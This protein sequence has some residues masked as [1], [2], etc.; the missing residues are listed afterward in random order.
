MKEGI[1]EKVEIFFSKFRKQQY[2]KGELL[3]RAQDAPSG[4]FYLKKGLV[5]QY[6]ISQKGEEL[7]VNVFKNPSF[8]PMGWAINQT[9]NNYFFEAIDEVEILK[10]PTQ[11]VIEFV[12]NNPDVLYNLLG[13]VYRGIE[14]LLTKMTYL[15]SGN[16]YGRLLTELIISAKRFGEGQK[17]IEV[18]VAEKELASQTGMTRETVS[19]E[20]KVLKDKGLLTFSRNNLFIP[21]LELL[22]KELWEG[23]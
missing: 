20:M 15:M 23:V 13:R 8:F 3:I 14:G 5:R 11:E 10:A 12:K 18:T 9:P 22:E 21:D 2:K 17:N 19:R 6:L 7:V 4:I 16:A 1:Q